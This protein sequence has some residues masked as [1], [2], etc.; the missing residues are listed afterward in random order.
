[1]D[2]DGVGAKADEVGAVSTVGAGCT[3]P[4][5]TDV[6]DTSKEVVRGGVADE[7]LD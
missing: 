4:M 6:C 3:F 5:L 2:D 7:G 1:M